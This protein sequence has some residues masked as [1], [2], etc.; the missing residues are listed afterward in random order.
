MALADIIQT[1]HGQDVISFRQQSKMGA[2]IEL[3]KL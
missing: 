1:M 3:M 2:E